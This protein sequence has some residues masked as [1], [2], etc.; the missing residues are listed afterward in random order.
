L[1]VDAVVHCAKRL[2]VQ[3]VVVLTVPVTMALTGAF[4]LMVNVT[5]AEK[6][7][8]DPSVSI[9]SS[10]VIVAAT[11]V[12][13]A[14]GVRLTSGLVEVPIPPPTTSVPGEA[15]VDRITALLIVSS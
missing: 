2:G 12:R 9:V 15:A 1:L 13:E 11:L 7:P 8:D 4:P 6:V 5:I 10:T 3:L 14:G